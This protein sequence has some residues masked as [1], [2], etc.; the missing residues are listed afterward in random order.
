MPGSGERRRYIAKNREAMSK[1][2]HVGSSSTVNI[3]K[4][5]DKIPTSSNPWPPYS[6]N[7][8]V[9]LFNYQNALIGEVLEIAN[10]K[11]ESQGAAYLLSFR[12]Q[13]PSL[14][15][16]EEDKS[17]SGWTGSCAH[18]GA[19]SKQHLAQLDAIEL[20]SLSTAP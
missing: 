7:E 8:V 9:F 5:E 4:Q 15:D 16:V 6:P 13:L 20:S 10:N 3:L 18:K 17:Q 14:K 11:I 2:I 1:F 19:I 12:L